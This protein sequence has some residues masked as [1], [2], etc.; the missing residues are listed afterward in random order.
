MCEYCGCQ[1]LPQIADLTA[2]H[3]RV[4]ALISRVRTS[5]DAAEMAELAR[6]IA[7]VLAPHTA[8]EEEGL[9]PA[10]SGEFGEHV[11]ALTAEHR[12]IEAVLAEA[13]HGVPGDPAWPGRLLGAL[14][15]LREH[16]LTE[17][18]GVF[19]A[20]LGF[21]STGDWAAVDAVRARVGTTR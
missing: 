18:D 7:A 14:H 16:I 17:Q 4:V 2:E 1:A 12:Q 13:A 8:V 15:V 6:E 3:D 10:L 5:G 20:A 19:P 9:F 21:L 11:E